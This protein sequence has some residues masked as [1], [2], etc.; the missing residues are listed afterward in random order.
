MCLWHSYGPR[1]PDPPL[2]YL[3]SLAGLGVAFVLGL[4]EKE[5]TEDE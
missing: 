2:L 5:A 4:G 1:P 3:D